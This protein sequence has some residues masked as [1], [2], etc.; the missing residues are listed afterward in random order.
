MF[1]L[2][3]D[4]CGRL[5]VLDSGQTDSLADKPKQ[6]CPP[7]IA[8]F[9]VN[10]DVLLARYII[11]EKYVL[12]NSLFA[13]IIVDSR[14]E[15]CSDLHAYITDTWRFGLLVF[16][17]SDGYFWRFNHPLF[18]PDP[19]ASNLTL[20]GIHFQ[21]TDGIFGLS[22]SPINNYIDRILY[23]H[24]LSSF[25]EFYVY[26]SVLK[27]PSKVKN[28]A[29]DFKLFGE[30]RGPNGHSSASV[31]DDNGVMFYGLITQDSVACWD[32]NKGYHKRTTGIVAKNSDTLVFPNDIKVDSEPQQ[33]VWV[34]S[35][36]LP[37]FQVAP[38]NTDDYNYRILFANTVE[39]VRSTICDPNV[40]VPH[41]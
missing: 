13:N 23:F 8:V 25:R 27:D 39:A 41:D 15:D 12:Q 6:I 24:S 28:S 20:H 29:N 17:E 7:S 26:T 5:W 3:A 32:T 37:M 9:D 22:L 21:W 4:Q 19:L 36:K 35:N 40:Y 16:R 30:S 31:I 34:L 2:K 1:R 18:F 11:P 33:N 10:T 38:L 14:K